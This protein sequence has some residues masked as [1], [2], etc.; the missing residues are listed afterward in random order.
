MSA[1]GFIA[2]LVSSLAWPGVI[3][4]I[5]LIF[6]RQFGTML[7]RLARVRLGAG[8]AD[9]D[10][11]WNQTEAVV[12]QSIVA[13]GHPELTAAPAGSPLAQPP[14][15]DGPPRGLERTPQALVEDQ[16]LA[17]TD[18][19]RRAVRPSGSL[20]EGQLAHAEFDQLMEAALRAGKLDSATVRALDGLRHLR[21]LARADGSLAQRQAEEFTI[22][23]DAVSL[24]IQREAGSSWG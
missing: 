6:R 16:W 2:S 4:V 17:L 1:S 18:A 5:V 19:L 21:N 10:P 13:A 8:T 24:T 15:P 14:G 22:L 12:R 11:D 20:S 7:E 9:G 23:T 3:V